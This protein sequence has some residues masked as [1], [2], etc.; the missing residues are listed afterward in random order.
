MCVCACFPCCVCVFMRLSLCLYICMYSIPVSLLWWSRSAPCPGNFSLEVSLFT[1]DLQH[2]S[3]NVCVCACVCV[4]VCVYVR[5]YGVCVS[6]LVGL[7]AVLGWT[8]HGSQ[9]MRIV[10]IWLGLWVLPLGSEF[11]VLKSLKPVGR[12]TPKN[13]KVP[14]QHFDCVYTVY[15]QSTLVYLSK[16]R[17][18]GFCLG[19]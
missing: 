15:L 6:N 10:I 1:G 19:R 17:V 4:C 5:V 11:L 16:L 9:A 2:A 8:G 14:V 13:F 12:V 3:V 7:L 18:S